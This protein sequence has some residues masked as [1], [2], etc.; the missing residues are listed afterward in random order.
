MDS[1]INSDM[2]LSVDEMKQIME[3]CIA[4]VS[5]QS[6]KKSAKMFPNARRLLFTTKLERNLAPPPGGSYLRYIETLADNILKSNHVH[7][8][9]FWLRL[10]VPQHQR[11][12]SS[13]P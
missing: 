9:V 7:F 8:H 13:S 10:L 4:E 1:P 2:D 6:C 11:K 3:K 5:K 12:K